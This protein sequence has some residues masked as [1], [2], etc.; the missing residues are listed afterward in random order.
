METLEKHRASYSQQYILKN[1]QRSARELD[2]EKYK[3][4]GLCKSP[5]QLARISMPL[6]PQDRECVE[7]ALTPYVTRLDTAE[8]PVGK[9]SKVLKYAP[10]KTKNLMGEIPT[11]L[12]TAE[13]YRR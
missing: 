9:K 4:I 11:M 13:F 10:C 8:K 6:E 5:R 7:N 12:V 2:G 1:F 3:Y